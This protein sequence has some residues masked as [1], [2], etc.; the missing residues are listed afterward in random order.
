MY[1]PCMILVLWG[2]F[3]FSGLGEAEEKNNVF[4]LEFSDFTKVSISIHLIYVRV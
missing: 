4:I 2:C 3:F 1:V